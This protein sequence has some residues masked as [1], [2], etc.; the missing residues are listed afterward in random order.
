MEIISAFLSSPIF[1]GALAVL[2]VVLVRRSFLKKSK[3]RKASKYKK[4]KYGKPK[5]GTPGPTG[6][7]PVNADRLFTAQQRQIGH[8]RAGKQC[9]YTESKTRKRC[10]SVSE[11]GDH[12]YPYSKGGET[13][14]TNFVSAC[15]RHNQ[16]KSGNVWEHERL[17]IE[18]RRNDYFSKKY[19]ITVGGWR[20]TGFHVL[21]RHGQNDYQLVAPNHLELVQSF[22][23]MSHQGADVATRRR[24]AKI[25]NPG[26][27][28][29]FLWDSPGYFLKKIEGIDPTTG[30]W[31][32]LRSESAGR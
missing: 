24:I 9:E 17:V 20:K 3:Q 23:V 29:D 16:V 19:E 25:A 30:K 7:K 31:I 5:Y 21:F 27:L 28:C 11:E 14:L 6:T 2:V 22:K 26:E 18:N 1:F 13:S 4:S 12:F 15:K 32:P 8:Q 10:T